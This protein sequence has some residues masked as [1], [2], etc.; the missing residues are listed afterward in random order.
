[1]IIAYTILYL[2]ASYNYYLFIRF[3]FI[4]K[5]FFRYNFFYVFQ[6]KVVNKVEN[7]AS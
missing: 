5:L 4:L 3:L 1:M 2:N 7:I 6:S